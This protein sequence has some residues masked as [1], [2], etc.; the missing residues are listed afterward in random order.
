M[1]KTSILFIASLLAYS[2]SVAQNKIIG[3]W[4]PVFFSMDKIITADIKADTVY[5]S[6]TLDVVLKD[7]KDPAA[8]KE[9]MKFMAGIMLEKMKNTL[10]EF[11]AAGEYTETDTK[12]NTIKKGTYSFDPSNNLL[13]TTIGNKT[14]KFIVSFKNDK[15]IL[16]GELESRNG[17]KGLLVIEHE[18]L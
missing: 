4:K 11:L 7:D 12:R 10:Q 13:T 2:V 3:K 15:L 17:K 5:L 6:D 9:L 18:R 8:S 14:N 16:T 1:I